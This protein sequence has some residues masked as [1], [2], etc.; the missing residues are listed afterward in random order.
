MAALHECRGRQ[1]LH[2]SVRADVLDALTEVAMIQS[3]EASNRIEGIRTS[4]KRLRDIMLDSTDLKSRDEEEIAGYRDVLNTVH[5]SYEF[6]D[7]KPE[8]SFNCIAICIA[9]RRLR[10]WALQYRRQRDTG[11]PL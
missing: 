2:L 8:V 11:H 1:A 3:T 4:D 7:V 6:I 10:W 5:R 9:I